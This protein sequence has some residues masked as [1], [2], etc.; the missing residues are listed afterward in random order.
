VAQWPG[1]Q[2]V[3][4][5]PQNYDEVTIPVAVTNLE[6]YTEEVIEITARES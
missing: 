2:P 6:D 3:E 1:A 5:W 4:Q